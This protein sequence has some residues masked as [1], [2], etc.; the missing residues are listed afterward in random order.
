MPMEITLIFYALLM[1][2]LALIVRWEGIRRRKGPG[3]TPGHLAQV[4]TSRLAYTPPPDRSRRS[5]DRARR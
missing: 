5:L 3:F 2:A 4:G 1:M